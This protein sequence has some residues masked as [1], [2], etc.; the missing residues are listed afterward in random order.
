[1]GV[2]P[3]ALEH[4]HSFGWFCFVSA[5]EQSVR[6]TWGAPSAAPAQAATKDGIK[7]ESK[8]DKAK[9]KNAKQAAKDARLAQRQAAAAAKD[10]FK[11]DPNDPS[12][13]QFGDK[14]L[15]RSQGDPELRFIK[16]FHK[17]CDV[18]EKLVD[19]EV[20]IRARVQNSRAKGKMCFMMLRE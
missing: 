4:P 3:S 7:K 18:D 20:I 5:F 14:E 11:K 15:N 6:K 17:V 12:A 16:K 13:H 2:V 1:M 10:E 19:Q 9:G 8:E